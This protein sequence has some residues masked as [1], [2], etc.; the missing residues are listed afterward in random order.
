MY[1]IFLFSSF[2]SNEGIIISQF[3]RSG[4][5]PISPDPYPYLQ[6]SSDVNK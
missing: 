1:S 2:H 5:G 3:F 6:H 4:F